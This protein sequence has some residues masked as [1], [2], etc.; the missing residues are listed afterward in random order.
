MHGS[1]EY[2]PKENNSGPS[3]D[4]SLD[5]KFNLH[6]PERE[7]W[8]RIEPDL[9]SSVVSSLLFLA[10]S[11]SNQWHWQDGTPALTPSER[12]FFR[13]LILPTALWPMS[14]VA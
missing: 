1:E 14:V 12:C 7:M 4:S 10:L 9:S 13:V 8:L 6:N 11:Y 5:L 2:R 3:V